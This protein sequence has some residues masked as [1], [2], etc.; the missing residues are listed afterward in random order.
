[1][2]ASGWSYRTP[3]DP[4]IK[5]A[6]RRL[7]DEVFERGEYY[8]PWEEIW[9]YHDSILAK[10]PGQREKHERQYIKWSRT[11]RMPDRNYEPTSIQE[12]L[13]YNAESG[14]HSILDIDGIAEGPTFGAAA[15]VPD[16]DLLRV[17][18]TTQPTAEDVEAVDFDFGEDLERWQ[19]VYF[20]IYQD[21]QPSEIRF[22]G[23]SGD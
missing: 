23:C 22:D 10:P 12:L 2:G 17:F 9:R 16:E 15:P 14:T 11:F 1:M 18:G 4:D 7:Q 13:R 19:A 21:G 3:Y 8:K 6:L 5:A 20:V